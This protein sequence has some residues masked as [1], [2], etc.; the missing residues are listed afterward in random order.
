VTI[1]QDISQHLLTLYTWG[2]SGRLT[3]SSVW[4]STGQKCF[5]LH[6]IVKWMC[7]RRH[8]CIKFCW[9]LGKMTTEILKML[10]QAFRET[11]F[12]WF[13]T[14]D[15]QSHFKNDCISSHKSRQCWSLSMT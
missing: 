1:K 10:Q 6:H 7:W 14:S 15:W 8:F 11:V 12:S 13:K 4:W 2:A 3:E 5:S 9:K